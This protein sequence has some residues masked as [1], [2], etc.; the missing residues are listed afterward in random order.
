MADNV[1]KNIETFSE[2]SVGIA[3]HGHTMRTLISLLL[4]EH[5]D[6]A[7]R[8]SYLGCFFAGADGN[9]RAAQGN[10]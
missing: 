10:N 2:K 3:F 8:D 4:A 5:A 6:G 7:E 9:P 1:R